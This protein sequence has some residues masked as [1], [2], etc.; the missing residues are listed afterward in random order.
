MLYVSILILAL[1]L[2][3]LVML[4]ATWALSQETAGSRIVLAQVIGSLVFLLLFPLA[5]QLRWGAQVSDLF[6][7]LGFFYGCSLSWVNIL[8]LITAGAVAL[9]AIHFRARR[10]QEEWN[11]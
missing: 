6:L 9:G 3:P 8:F 5:D 2:L 1:H 10:K 4:R 7:D 11:H